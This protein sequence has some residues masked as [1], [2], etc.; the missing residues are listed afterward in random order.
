[1]KVNDLNQRAMDM[2]LGYARLEQDTYGHAWTREEGAMG[3]VA[4][5]SKAS[6][7]LGHYWLILNQRPQRGRRT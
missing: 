7:Q 2:R 3:F 1:M 6:R 5:F 4:Q